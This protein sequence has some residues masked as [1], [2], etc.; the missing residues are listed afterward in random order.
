M[1]SNTWKSLSSMKPLLT[2]LCLFIF[3]TPTFSFA[4]EPYEE[5]DTFYQTD[6]TITDGTLAKDTG[7]VPCS[8]EGCSACDFVVLANTIIKWLISFSFILFAFMAVMAGFKLVTSGGNPSAMSEAKKGFT[9]VFIGLIIIMAAWLF[10]DTLLRGLLGKDGT[11]SDGTI[12]GFGPWAQVKCA[13]QNSA[14]TKNL[15][16]EGDKKTNGTSD[17]A[18]PG[19]SGEPSPAGAGAAGDKGTAQCASGNTACSVAVLKQAGLTDAQ[20]NVMSCIAFS[21]SSGNPAAVNPN[22]GACGT[23]QFLRSTWGSYARGSCASYSQCTNAACS[24]QTVV[25]AVR[26]RGYKDWTCKNCNQ[27][28]PKCVSNYGG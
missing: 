4:A 16:Y 28:A 2:L 12:T 19:D 18:Q 11:L 1:F 13:T 8:G 10:V 17:G 27:W 26:I 6:P 5:Y 3:L 15:G 7:F 20:A 22:G 9:N 21:E 25:N 23:F 14:T 24:T